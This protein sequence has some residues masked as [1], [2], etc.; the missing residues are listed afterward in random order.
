MIKLAGAN[1]AIAAAQDYARDCGYSI[2]VTVCDSMGHLIAHQRMDNALLLSGYGSVEKAI[3]SAGLGI[4][5][6]IESDVDLYRSS[7]GGVL[8]H[9]LAV[10]RRPGGLP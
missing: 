10:I 6:G 9:G 1:R 3:A 8:A 4:P 5:S 7:V 2:S